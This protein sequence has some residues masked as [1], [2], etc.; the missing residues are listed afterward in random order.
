MFGP[1]PAQA[2]NDHTNWAILIAGG[3]DRLNNHAR[4][5]NDIGEMYEILTGTYDYTA[6]HIFVL[7]ADGNPPTDAN[8]PDPNLVLG[9]PQV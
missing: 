1:V 5:W 4:Y 2:S 7:Y 3:L 8:C 6:D 9:Y